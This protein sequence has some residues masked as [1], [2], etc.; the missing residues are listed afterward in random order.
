MKLAFVYL[1][2]DDLN[3]VLSFYRER[4]GLSEAWREGDH[5][6]ALALPDTDVALMIGE[7]SADDDREVGPLFIVDDVQAFYAQQRGALDFRIEP[8]EIPPG[9]YAAFVDPAGNLIR[10]MDTTKENM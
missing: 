10:V 5:T 6:A 4:L 7:P 9:F 8:R 1:P 2:T 3:S